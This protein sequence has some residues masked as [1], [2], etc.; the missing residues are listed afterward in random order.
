MKSIEA[1]GKLI[2]FCIGISY[3]MWF[4]DNELLQWILFAG[5][6]LTIGIPHG[7]LDHLLTH[8]QLTKKQLFTFIVKYVSIIAVYLFI[9]IIL[10]LPALLAFIVMSAY[11]F[12]QSHYLESPLKNKSLYI[13]TGAYYLSVIFWGDFGYTAEILSGIVDISVLES[14]GNYFIIG[15]FIGTNLLLLVNPIKPLWVKPFEMILLGIL[16]YHLPLLMGFILYFGFWHSLPSMAQEYKFL[17][18][19]VLTKGI[20]GFMLKLLPFTLLSI[21]GIFLVLAYLQYKAYEDLLLVF[22]VLVSLISAPHIFYMDRF[23]ES[24]KNQN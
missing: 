4:E 5:I 6:L 9:W 11:H 21:G 22:F 15:F 10:P 12:G 2:G 20:Y 3:L 1:A 7:A 14:Y 23:L 8:P 17:H 13:L 19:K 16:L 24:P 18:H